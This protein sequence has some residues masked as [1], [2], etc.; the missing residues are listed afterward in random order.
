MI[1]KVC[2]DTLKSAVTSPQA[3]YYV[4]EM[5]AVGNNLVLVPSQ[6]HLMEQT[7]LCTKNRV[8]I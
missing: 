1:M 2:R 6:Y 5:K 3:K 7:I 8:V 4:A